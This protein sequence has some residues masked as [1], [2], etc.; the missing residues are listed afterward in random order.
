MVWTFKEW[1]DANKDTFNDRRKSR[2]HDDPDYR[3]RVLEQNSKS[4]AKRK[5]TQEGLNESADEEDRRSQSG[6]N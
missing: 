4:R 5:K 3:A 2:Y 6:G 1:Y